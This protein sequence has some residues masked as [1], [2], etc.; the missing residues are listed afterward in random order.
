MIIDFSLQFLVESNEN[1][2]YYLRYSQTEPLQ[3]L[4]RGKS[5]W[6]P[7][8][9][10]NS[11]LTCWLSYQRYNIHRKKK[12][13]MLISKIPRLFILRKF[14]NVSDLFMKYNRLHAY[15][16]RTIRKFFMINSRKF[17][18]KNTCFNYTKHASNLTIMLKWSTTCKLL[19]R[20]ISIQSN[21]KVI[22]ERLVIER[23][24][25]KK[26]ITIYEL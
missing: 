7:C 4:L 21:L 13:L 18:E 23:N 6:N 9:D 12:W 14:A 3:K 5:I 11:L 10:S 24:I 19:F 1:S 2:M 22:L 20:E 25:D 16:E 8:F 26:K 17:H 15:L